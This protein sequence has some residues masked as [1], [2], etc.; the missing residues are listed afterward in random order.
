MP[1]QKQC[2]NKFIRERGLASPNKNPP[3]QDSCA[4]SDFKLKAL[5]NSNFFISP[6][7]LNEYRYEREHLFLSKLC[8][9]NK[10]LASKMQN[11]KKRKTRALV[12]LI[13]KRWTAPYTCHLSTGGGFSAKFRLGG[14]RPQF[15]NV[16]VG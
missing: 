15:Q 3:F 16:T 14:C 10:I 1:E 12:P 11:L 9:Q 6:Y 4:N 13:M 5:M 2:A 7:F 8:T